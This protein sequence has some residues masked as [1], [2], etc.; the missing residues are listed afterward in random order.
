MKKHSFSFVAAIITLSLS[1][2]AATAAG[3]GGVSTASFCEDMCACQRCTSDELDT[4]K[5]QGA[6]AADQI[7]AAGCSSQFED[8]LACAGTHVTCEK[9]QATYEGC[10]AEL[11]A[12]SKCSSTLDGLGKNACERASDSIVARIESCGGEVPPASSGTGPEVECNDSLAAL[13][14]C[15]AACIDVAACSIL[16]NDPNQ[17]ATTEEVQAFSDCITL[18]Q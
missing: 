17:P 14:T 15:Q 7:D 16:V 12:M 5:E 4:C 8:F 6:K 1:S 3:C 13:A 18:C 11:L 10:D 2:V 9:D